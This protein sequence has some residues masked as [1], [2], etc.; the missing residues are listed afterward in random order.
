MQRRLLLKFLVLAAVGLLLAIPLA[1]IEGTITERVTYKDSA[2]QAIAA[3]SA[4]AQLLVG[5]VLSVP[6]QEEYDEEEASKQESDKPRR[7]V[8]RRRESSVT[9]LPKRLSLNGS[10]QTERRAYGIYSVPV[11]GLHAVI[12]GVFDAAGDTDLSPRGRNSTITWG[13]PSLVIGV[14]DVRGLATEPRL[15]AGSDTLTAVRGTSGTSLRSG[16]HGQLQQTGLPSTETPFEVQIDLIGTEALSVVPLGGMT[17]AQLRGDWADPNFGGSFLPR[18]RKVDRSGFEGNWAISGLASG[19]QR[20]DLSAG[21]T[22]A[23]G[24]LPCFT[25]KL[26]DP[27]DVYHLAVRAVKYGLLFIVAIFAAFFAYEVIATLPIHPVQYVLVGLAQAMFFLLLLSLSEHISF[28]FAYLGAATGS[29]LLIV[30]YLA[31]VLRGTGRALWA[32]GALALLY[33]ALF[34]VLESEQNALLLGSLLLFALLAAL[35]LGTR[36]VDWYRIGASERA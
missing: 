32:G 17:T 20:E 19:V 9:L 8:R 25:I 22:T 6:F 35:M 5:P 1:M 24:S 13:H 30:A 36:R 11:Y 15:Q 23:V 34:G 26:I 3:A 29:V 2:I 21:A 10:L 16:F 12:A 7:W 28:A 27:I 4:G 14:T 31:A 33:A 18:Q